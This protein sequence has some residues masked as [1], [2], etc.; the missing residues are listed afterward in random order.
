MHSG[1][2]SFIPST[3]G[4]LS[5]SSGLYP[6][7]QASLAML[8]PPRFINRLR[9]FPLD[10]RY[11]PVLTPPTT[12]SPPRKRKNLL[13]LDLRTFEGD[14]SA[15]KVGKSFSQMNQ[16]SS[17]ISIDD[18]KYFQNTMD[19]AFPS[20]SKAQSDARFCENSDDIFIDIT[21]SDNEME[22]APVERVKS[23]EQVFRRSE[24]ILTDDASNHSD[25][26]DE[27]VDIE[28]NEDSVVFSE[29]LSRTQDLDNTAVLESG[30]NVFEDPNLHSKALEGFA[31][32]FDASMYNIPDMPMREIKKPST[33]AQ[34]RSK[35][36]R[37]RVKSRKQIVDEETTSPVSGTIIRKL[38][39]GE[40]L[41]VRKGDIDPVRLSGE[42]F[43]KIF[44][45]SHPSRHLMSSKSLRRQ[46]L[47]SLSSRTKLAATFASCAG[48]C[49]R[50][51]SASPST[52]AVAS[53]TSSIAVRSVIKF[54]I[55][56]PT[57][58]RTSDGTSREFRVKRKLRR[59]RA[60]VRTRRSW[61]LHR[62]WSRQVST[63]RS[64]RVISAAEFL[65]GAM[66]ERIFLPNVTNSRR[67]TGNLTSRSISCRITTSKWILLSSI[68][69]QQWPKSP[70][71]CTP[72]CIRA[73]SRDSLTSSARGDAFN[74][75]RSSTFSRDRRSS[76]FAI[77]IIGEKIFIQREKVEK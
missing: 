28:S 25:D 3:G 10:L 76:T 35:N 13:N 52:A 73:F 70:T 64:F 66:S 19:H 21:S 2:F 44:S 60:R 33:S 49:T 59:R 34:H 58:P 53:F 61:P 6:M 48:R 67:S 31:K 30:K 8:Q 46:K 20:T 57:S 15:V 74:P 12:P 50:I 38:H 51:R 62:L 22:N 27:I 75:S 26:S 55:V 29:L 18:K 39:D 56:L 68:R 17:T 16:F 36:E 7:P 9:E 54:S 77:R 1:G 65:G 32:L 71:K 41:V 4:A 42:F 5:S 63:K 11:R 37:K 69:H 40:E 43:R 45:F 14:E 24:S 47:R 72:W 23:V